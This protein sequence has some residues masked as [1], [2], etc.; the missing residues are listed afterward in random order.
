ML[1]APP[2]TVEKATRWRSHLVA[3][4][5]QLLHGLTVL[6]LFVLPPLYLNHRAEPA[7]RNSMQGLYAMLVFGSGRIV[8]NIFAGQVSTMFDGDILKVFG[9]AT[10][11]AAGAFVLHALFFRDRSETAIEP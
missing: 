9:I 5:T 2:P 3:V 10:G 7:F 6:A 11:I 1:L 8:G 4:G